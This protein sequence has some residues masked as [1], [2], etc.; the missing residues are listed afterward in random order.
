MKI[1][2]GII[3]ESYIVPPSAYSSV[4]FSIKKKKSCNGSS[5]EKLR[6]NRVVLETSISLGLGEEKD[7]SLPLKF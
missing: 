4:P 5:S 3:S 1:S 2:K 6:V 7:I